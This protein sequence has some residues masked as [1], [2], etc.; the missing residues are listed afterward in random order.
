[1][2]VSICVLLAYVFVPFNVY[3]RR[4]FRESSRKGITRMHVAVM[5][6]KRQ[7]GDE[8]RTISCKVRNKLQVVVHFRFFKC[9]EESWKLVRTVW[10][11]CLNEIVKCLAAVCIGDD[12][13]MIVTTLLNMFSKHGNEVL[14]NPVKERMW[15]QS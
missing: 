3:I 5:L 15:D 14:L 13:N 4:T 7:L 11:V 1:M 2:F 8:K 10:S 9:K 12:T 6:L